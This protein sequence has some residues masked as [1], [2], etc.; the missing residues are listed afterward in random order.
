VILRADHKT[1]TSPNTVNE[2]LADD[3]EAL[4]RIERR[5]RTFFA[6]LTRN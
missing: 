4:L 1:V 2:A 3:G 5:G 6:A